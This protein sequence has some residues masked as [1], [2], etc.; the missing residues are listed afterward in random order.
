[1][2][3]RFPLNT[4]LRF[5]ES[6]E[7]RSWLALQSANLAVQRSEV[8]LEQLEGERIEWLAGRLSALCSGIRARDLEASSELYYSRKRTELG[9]QLVHARRRAAEKLAEFRQMR[10]KREVLE[11]L[12]LRARESYEA[13]RS[14][15]E[16]A[17]LDEIFLFRQES[18][19]GGQNQDA[20]APRSRQNHENL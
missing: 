19:A 11:S 16:Q 15:R 9:Q 17:R 12:R 3:F 13:N 1:M 14:R 7:H 10:Q 2:G 20:A 4:L 5:R 18:G 6:L 8:A